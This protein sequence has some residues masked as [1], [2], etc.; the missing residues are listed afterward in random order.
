MVAQGIEPRYLTKNVWR[1]SAGNF[2]GPT[3]PPQLDHSNFIRTGSARDRRAAGDSAVEDGGLAVGAYAVDARQPGARTRRS[4]LL[5]A[6]PHGGSA[7]PHTTNVA[8]PRFV[9]PGQIPMAFT[10]APLIPRR[11]RLASADPTSGRS[12]SGPAI[13][14]IPARRDHARRAARA[15][16][17]RSCPSAPRACWKAACFVGC[18]RPIRRWREPRAFKARWCWRRSSA[19][20][21]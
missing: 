20:P 18:S 14:G 7:S 12:T 11:S 3:L 13:P 10:T 21:A 4:G 9:A 5:A 8:I 1:Q 19:K 2:L 15:T 6:Q 17:G 16:S